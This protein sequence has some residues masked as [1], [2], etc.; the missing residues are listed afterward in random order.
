[1]IHSSQK[2]AEVVMPREKDAKVR[3]VFKTDPL[4]VASS[5][6]ELTHVFTC[7]PR[8]VINFLPSS[9]TLTTP[10][11]TRTPSTK[12]DTDAIRSLAINMVRPIVQVS[13]RDFDDRKQEIT[14]ELWKAATDVGFFYLKDHGLSEVRLSESVKSLGALSETHNCLVNELSSFRNCQDEIQQMFRLSE[15]FFKLPAETKAN[16]RFD[17]VR[18]PCRLTSPCLLVSSAD[19]DAPL[20]RCSI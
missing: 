6:S 3:A 12:E 15:A 5:F 7:F 13:L 1:M 18:P 4:A 16:Y 8:S 17:L 11:N 19:P 2:S 10:I 20:S 14:K 9:H